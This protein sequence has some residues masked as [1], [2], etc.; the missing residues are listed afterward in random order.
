MKPSNQLLKLRHV[1]G[2]D[3]SMVLILAGEIFLAD[4]RGVE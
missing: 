3:K 2:V 1:H 4:K